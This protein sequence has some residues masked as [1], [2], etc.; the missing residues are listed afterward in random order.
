MQVLDILSVAIL[1]WPC[2]QSAIT[3][4]HSWLLHAAETKRS[5]G[6]VWCI[7]HLAQ[8]RLYIFTSLFLRVLHA[9]SIL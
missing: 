3:L 9:Q 5:S 4:F 2:K 1:T 8:C 7:D 6:S